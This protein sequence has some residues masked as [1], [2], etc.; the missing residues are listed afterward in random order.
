MWL[1]S[2]I[3]EPA[4]KNTHMRDWLLYNSVL[5][6]SASAKNTVPEENQFSGWKIYLGTWFQSFSP[7]W[8]GGAEWSSSIHGRRSVSWKQTRK[9]RGEEESMPGI[10]MKGPPMM[11]DLCLWVAPSPKVSTAFQ[12]RSDRFRASVQNMSLWGHSDSNRHKHIFEHEFE[13]LEIPSKTGSLWVRVLGTFLLL[14]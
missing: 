10:A 4:L 8:W 11:N 2:N 13:C 14:H 5:V 1:L 7:P 9:Q 6:T 12:N 3:S